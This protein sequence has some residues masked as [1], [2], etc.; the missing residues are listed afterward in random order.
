M[1]KKNGRKTLYR[2][3][4]RE[5]QTKMSVY[6]KHFNFWSFKFLLCWAVADAALQMYV[7]VNENG[8][9]E[10]LY[11]NI[12]FFS[13]WMF[14]LLNSFLNISTAKVEQIMNRYLLGHLKSVILYII[15]IFYWNSVVKFHSTSASFFITTPLCSR[16]S[17]TRL[18]L[19]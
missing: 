14:A 2:G 8:V 1:K 18:E 17:S 5:Y 9:Y 11:W 15:H 13:S 16:S 12:V 3:V 6:R 10:S 4:G 7:L 19:L